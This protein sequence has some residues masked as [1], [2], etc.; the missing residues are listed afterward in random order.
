MQLSKAMLRKG[1][2]LLILLSVG[3]IYGFAQQGADTIWVVHKGKQ[4]FVRHTVEMGETLFMLAARFEAPAAATA[5][6]N[7]I[8]Y[9]DGLAEGSIF[10][11]PVGKYNYLRINSVVESRPIYYRVQKGDRL[12]TVS[13]L[14]NVS[15]STIQRWND[16]PLPETF[17]GQALQVGWIKFNEDEQP[18]AAAKERERAAREKAEAEALAKAAKDSTKLKK[19]EGQTEEESDL[20]KQFHEKNQGKVLQET[21]GAAVFFKSQASS[22]T[23]I[24]YAFF[25]DAPRGAILSIFNP[26]TKKVVYAKVI[27][28]LPQI[29]KYHNARLGLSIDAA[30]ELQAHS[31]RVFVKIKY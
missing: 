21:S 6:L 15:Q 14:F 1:I 12:R 18:F 11:I 23:S 28:P 4:L 30:K 25:D 8:S 13:H 9:A 17:S 22:G 10:K 5:K 24:H 19:Q 29:S 26:S 31:Q 7:G 3:Q 2:C 16:L 20:S 27:G